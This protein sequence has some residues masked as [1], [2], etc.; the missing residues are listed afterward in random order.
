MKQIISRCAAAALV[1]AAPLVAQRAPVG[2]ATRSYVTV[3]TNV[4]ALTNV[5]V[6]DGT[7]AAAREGQTIIVRDGRIAAVGGVPLQVSAVVSAL[8]A[9]PVQLCKY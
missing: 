9:L 4:L 7:G 2:P 3:D 8:L 5:R 1:V 6:I